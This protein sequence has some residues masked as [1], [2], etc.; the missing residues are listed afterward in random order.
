[1][2]QGGIATGRIAQGLS[3]QGQYHRNTFDAVMPPEAEREHGCLERREVGEG[4]EEKEEEAIESM[5]GRTEENEMN[6]LEV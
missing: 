3:G 1:M 5:Q 2:F 6:G 4:D